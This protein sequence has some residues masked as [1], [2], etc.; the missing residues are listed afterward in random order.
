M[1]SEAQSDNSLLVG[2]TSEKEVQ[3]NLCSAINKGIKN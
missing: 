2:Q 3:M 1:F